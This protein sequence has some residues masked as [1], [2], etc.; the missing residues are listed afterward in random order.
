MSNRVCTRVEDLDPGLYL[1]V[2]D[3]LQ[4]E[5]LQAVLSERFVWHKPAGCPEELDLYTLERGDYRLLSRQLSCQ[6]AIAS[7]G[8]HS[9]G[10]LAAFGSPLRR[11]GAPY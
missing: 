11:W 9:L 4:R 3:P 10:M 7:D 8:C 5:A 2:R 1:L 6:Q